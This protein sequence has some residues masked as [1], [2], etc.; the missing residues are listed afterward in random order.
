MSVKFVARTSGA[1][2]GFANIMA[3]GT[4]AFLLQE[5]LHAYKIPVF[6]FFF[7]GG[8]VPILFLWAWGF[9]RQL[10][11]DI[12]QNGVSHRC[13]CVKT[14]CQGGVW[15]HFGGVATSLKKYRAIRGV[16]AIVSQYRT[17]WLDDRGAW[18]WLAWLPLQSLAVKKKLFF[19]CANFGRWKTLKIC[20]KVPVNFF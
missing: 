4:C 20:W 9:F 19:V 13:A 18:Q 11:C 12:L 1:G 6:W 17:I 2:N 8:E 16:A 7:G 3:P 5:N 10:S 15:H 14:N